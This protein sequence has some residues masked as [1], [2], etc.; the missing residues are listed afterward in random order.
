MCGI[1]GLI[2]A[3]RQ[4]RVDEQTVRA[5][6]DRI[7][8]R[9]PDGE[10]IWAEGHV[11]L[12]M[13]RLSIIDLEGGNQPIYN[14]DRSVLTVYNGEIYNFQE[15]K[16]ELL[17]KGHKFYTHCDTEVIVHLYEEH[18]ADFVQKLRGMFALAVFDK[19]AN[20]LLLARDRLGK[21]PLFY[22]FHDGVLY[23]GS[24]I[25]TILAIAPELA[26][27]DN[28]G[29][30]QFF[31]YGYIPDPLTSFKKIRKLP[32]GC[33]LEF[34]SGEIHIRP[35]WSLPQ[36]A[37]LR[38]NEQECIER[39]E[40]IFADAVRMR[41]ISDVPLGA[42]LSGGVDSSAVVA[43]MARV[44]SAPVKTF[45]IGFG[46][47]DFNEAGY[48]R[49][50]AEK[51]HTD[52]HELH[53]DPNLWETLQD[54]TRI[55]DEPFADSSI[56]PTYH[57]SKLAREHVTVALSGDGGDELFVGY[58]R[59]MAHF[60]RRHLD[61]LPR[62]AKQSYRAAVYPLLPKSVRGR[63]LAHNIA[64]NSRDRYIDGVSHLSSHDADMTLLSPEFLATTG[65]TPP[66][67]IMR[68]HFDEAPASDFMSR[69]QYTDIKT[70]MTADVLAKVDRMSMA[71]SLEVRV[72]LLDHVF[73]EFAAQ[74]P[75]EMKYQNGTRKY[76]LRKLAERLG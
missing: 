28:E 3:D 64:L 60:R 17:A 5:M 27:I 66:E 8:Y 20:R 42:L 26:E 19:K 76:L 32:P 2:G 21:K 6:C 40:S 52:H 22:A 49:T 71:S 24:E 74:I 68:R 54:L 4:L 35:Y 38:M 65:C 70:Y 43:M 53:V 61:L 63:K 56:I 57:V 58:D 48:A 75:V 16:N 9:G 39:L 72:P 46:K 50:V 51:F 45:S 34:E 30:M 47:A 15:L 7:V 13:R 14:E 59:Y 41:L 31:Y 29:L 25:K 1:A 36:F 33:R 12:G 73:V 69:M 10:G 55:L 23:F 44:S 11:G 62:W 67:A 18:G 37:S